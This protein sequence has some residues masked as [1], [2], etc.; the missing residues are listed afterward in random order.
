MKQ[1]KYY[2][3]IILALF[4]NFCNAADILDI[5]RKWYNIP[6]TVKGIVLKDVSKNYDELQFN[7]YVNIDSPIITSYLRQA[8]DSLVVEKWKCEVKKKYSNY[9]GGVVDLAG[10][11]PYNFNIYDGNCSLYR[12]FK[13]QVISELTNC[14][15]QSLLSQNTNYS[16]KFNIY[17]SSATIK[18]PKALITTITLSSN[19]FLEAYKIKKYG[20]NVFGSLQYKYEM[21]HGIELNKKALPISFENG[22]LL[23]SIEIVGNEIIYNAYITKKQK[24]ET[25]LGQFT[26]DIGHIIWG[27]ESIRDE[28]DFSKHKGFPLLGMKLTYRWYV[29]GDNKP[30][31]Y[32]TITYPALHVTDVY[33]NNSPSLDLMLQSVG[34][35]DDDDTKCIP[36]QLLPSVVDMGT[37]CGLWETCNLGANSPEDVGSYYAWADTTGVNFSIDIADYHID[38]TVKCIKGNSKYDYPMKDTPSSRIPSIN[39]W[40]ELL[41]KSLCI[42]TS[43]KGVFGYKIVNELGDAIFLPLCGYRHGNSV[44][45]THPLCQYWTANRDTNGNHQ[46]TSILIDRLSVTIANPIWRGLPIRAIQE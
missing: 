18:Q 11:T 23:K 32:F 6:S 43:Y 12:L 45:T 33:P 37:E 17:T 8:H 9:G 44:N 36:I 27:I 24:E 41:N 35:T 26:I 20:G 4:T 46:A 19:D 15:S 3:T 39:D 2:I 21:I 16:V 34:Y 5:F 30:C 42:Y 40:K 13:A 22:A 38:D 29:E 7:C 28:I 25:S 31:R 14:I 1:T 10:I